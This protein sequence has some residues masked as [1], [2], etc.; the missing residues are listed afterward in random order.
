MDTLL[1]VKIFDNRYQ[2]IK[3]NSINKKVKNKQRF[4]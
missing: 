1:C 3:N 4:S 2:P